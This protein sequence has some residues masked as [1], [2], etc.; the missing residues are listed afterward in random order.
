M[1]PSEGLVE[2]RKVTSYRGVW[3]QSVLIIAC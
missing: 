1:K 3:E 2:V